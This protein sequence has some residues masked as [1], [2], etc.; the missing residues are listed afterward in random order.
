MKSMKLTQ[1]IPLLTFDLPL[2]SRYIGTTFTITHHQLTTMYP[3]WALQATRQKLK[4][5]YWFGY[6][7]IHFATLY[8]LA[9]VVTLPFNTHLNQFYLAGVLTAG[10]IC[11][12]IITIT[13]YAPRFFSDYLPKLETIT[14]ELESRQNELIKDQ[15]QKGLNNQ[16]A[17]E[18][19]KLGYVL[20]QITCQ[21]ERLA[22]LQNEIPKCRQKQMHTFSQVLIFYAFYKTAGLNALQCNDVTAGQLMKL[23]GKD[24]GGIKDS[25]QLIIGP[26]Q[27]LSHRFRTEIQNRFNDVYAFFEELQFSAGISLLKS[28]ESKFRE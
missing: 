4:A 17:G 11:F 16:I 28:L 24:Q 8:S 15:L 21:R 19:E 7:L 2:D 20:D 27:E 9:I 1:L 10:I 26:K 25:L 13:Q 23:F 14:A 18:Y 12:T 22:T 6:V 5:R 3:G